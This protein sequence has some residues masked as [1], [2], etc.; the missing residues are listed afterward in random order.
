MRPAIRSLK[1]RMASAARAEYQS[2]LSKCEALEAQDDFG[3]KIAERLHN[4]QRI[5][6]L[7]DAGARSVSELLLIWPDYLPN[8]AREAQHCASLARKTAEAAPADI[9]KQGRAAN[10]YLIARALEMRAE[11]RQTTQRPAI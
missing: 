5:A 8:M 7:F 9:E 10:L 1:S 2:R 3:H 11:S 6:W 4:W